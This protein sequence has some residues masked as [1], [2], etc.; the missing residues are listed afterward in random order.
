[1]AQV[2]L[3]ATRKTVRKLLS[4]TGL[5]FRLA[6]ISEREGHEFAPL[7]PDQIVAQGVGLK[8]VEQSGVAVYPACYV[9]CERVSNTLRE[10][11]RTF[12]GRA[13]VNVEVRASRE[14]LSQTESD[15]QAYVDA[16]TGV[17]DLNRGDWEDG[18]F[19]P[20]TYDVVFQTA[21]RGGRGFIQSATVSFDLEVSLN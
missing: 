14:T 9:F 8:V 5:A 21:Q 12:S 7:R 3:L 17:L 18:L 19:H 13:R 11:F 4:E 1:M 15:L 20:G 2:S 16:V 10:K 6:A